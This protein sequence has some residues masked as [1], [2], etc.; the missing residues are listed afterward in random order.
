MEKEI[1]FWKK[2]FLD[3]SKKFFDDNNKLIEKDTSIH[4]KHIYELH[5]RE[6]SYCFITSMYDVNFLDVIDIL[7]EE[8]EKDDNNF[9]F[10][11]LLMDLKKYIKK[12]L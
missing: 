11:A 10:C 7:I 5:K 2:V 8:S 3:L 6:Y 12:E 1:D 9:E 4:L